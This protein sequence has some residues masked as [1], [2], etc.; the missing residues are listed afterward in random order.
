MIVFFDGRGDSNTSLNSYPPPSSCCDFL[1]FF[2]KTSFPPFLFL[3]GKNGR[4]CCKWFV[5]DFVS[6]KMEATIMSALLFFVCKKLENIQLVPKQF[7]RFIRLAGGNCYQSS[8]IKKGLTL[9]KYW[10]S[11]NCSSS[12]LPS[13]LCSTVLLTAH[14]PPV[15]CA[16]K[17]NTLTPRTPFFW[18]TDWG[19]LM[20]WTP[21]GAFPRN[22]VW[23]PETCCD[24][25]LSAVCLRL[26]PAFH[27]AWG[28]IQLF[29]PVDD[30]TTNNRCLSKS[31]SVDLRSPLSSAAIK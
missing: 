22:L 28:R 13:Q 14:F 6:V 26:S 8:S 20:V 24:K 3:S 16:L 18:R 21:H 7:T 11:R 5:K 23:T 2:F 1:Y 12:F 9:W 10:A 31:R 29:L 25:A 4:G 19:Y 17:K 15:I 30:F 27:S